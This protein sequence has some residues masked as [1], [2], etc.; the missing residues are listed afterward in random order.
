MIFGGVARLAGP[1]TG[2]GAPPSFHRHGAHGPHTGLQGGLAFLLHDVLQVPG[3]LEGILGVRQGR[4]G[5]EAR[6]DR[7]VNGCER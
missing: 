3:A 2:R 6:T 4:R 1:S 5:C 7:V